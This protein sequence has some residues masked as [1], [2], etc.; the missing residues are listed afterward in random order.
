VSVVYGPAKK[1]HIAVHEKY[2]AIVTNRAKS[3][4]KCSVPVVNAYAGHEFASVVA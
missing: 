2:K 1:W 3:N 4:S